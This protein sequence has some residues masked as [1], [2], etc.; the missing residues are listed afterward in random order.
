MAKVCTREKALPMEKVAFH[1]TQQLN[2]E[3]LTHLPG[4]LK[5]KD[6]GTKLDLLKVISGYLSNITH[7]K[8]LIF[9]NQ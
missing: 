3:Q 9:S 2:E 6:T 1:R 7:R 5:L 8:G 4:I